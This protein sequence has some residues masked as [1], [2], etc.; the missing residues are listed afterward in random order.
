[1]QPVQE[2]DVKAKKDT[3]ASPP[4]YEADSTSPPDL[5]A[6]FSKL[7]LRQSG[8]KPTV[9]QC[10]AHLKLLEAFSQLREDVSTTDGLYG[11]KD[12]LLPS[13]RD[14]QQ[15]SQL[16]AK[17][18]EKRWAVYVTIAVQRFTSYFRIILPGSPLLS[19]DRMETKSYAQIADQGVPLQF[20]EDNLPPLGKRYRFRVTPCIADRL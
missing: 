5:T 10:T 15:K 6:A 4:K 11:L 18:R 13:M 1:M 3:S 16:L 8:S 7:D 19:D 9:D 17:I 2:L 20:T 14:D 12:S